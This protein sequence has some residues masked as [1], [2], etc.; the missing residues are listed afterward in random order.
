MGGAPSAPDI[1]RFAAGLDR[2][3]PGLLHPLSRHSALRFLGTARG[4]WEG[5][6][7]SGLKGLGSRRA[8][9]SV[10]EAVHVEPGLLRSVCGSRD[11]EPPLSV[12]VDRSERAELQLPQRGARRRRRRRRRACPQV[13]ARHRR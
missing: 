11:D 1:L 3:M 10:D 8:A 4:P 9:G 2:R 6:T 5:A 13:H 12:L 7:P